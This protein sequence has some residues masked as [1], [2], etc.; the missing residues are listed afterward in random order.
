M[1]SFNKRVYEM[2][3]RI[4]VFAGTYPHLFGKDTLPAQLLEKIQAAIQA[5]SGH[6]L[7]QVSGMGAVRRSST[8]RSEARSALRSQLEAIS[9]TARSQKLPEF[10]MPRNRGDQSFLEVGKVFLKNAQP[11][12]QL[13][14][15]GHLPADFLE[16]L[17][18]AVQ[19][20]E[21]AIND[22]TV[23]KATRTSATR[24]IEQTRTE[25][26]S[27]QKRLDPIMENLLRDDQP[28]LA[29][30]QSCRHI[31]RV[32]PSKPVESEPPPSADPHIP[33]TAAATG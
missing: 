20:L 21:L 13:F 2:L 7:S 30:W 31:E 32:G 23:S 25:A 17:D 11:V 3:N 33:K 14:I 26:L 6:A 29:V 22:Q 10:W 19:N 5:L 15:D 9:R 16:K 28:T 24:A 4:V 1:N 12:K 18:I 27:A 8:S